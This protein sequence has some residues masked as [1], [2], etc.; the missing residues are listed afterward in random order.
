MKDAIAVAAREAG[1]DLPRAVLDDKARLEA[2]DPLGR[3]AGSGAAPRGRGWGG[4][5]EGLSHGKRVAQLF[6]DLAEGP[7]GTP[8]FVTDYP[9]EVSPLARPA[10][11]PVAHRALRAVRGGHGDRRTASRDRRPLE[12]RQ[13]F[14]DQSRERER[15][16][17]EATAWTTTTLRALG[18]GLPPTGGC[19]VGI[20][21]LSMI[22]TNSPSIRDVILFPHMRPA[23]EGMRPSSA[24]TPS[25][26]PFELL[27][28]LRYLT[29]KRKQAFIS[30]ISAI[31]V[32]GVVVGVMALMVALGLM[33][34]LQ[35]EIRSKILGTTAH[36]SLFRSRGEGFDDY[37]QVV[38]RAR[39]L[40]HVLG[41]APAVYGKGI[42]SSG[43]S[44]LAT[45]KGIVPSQER[46][47]T[48]IGS[49]V[50][51]GSLDALDKP[52]AEG[53]PPILLGRELASQIGVGA[54]DVVSVTSPNG[55][56]SPMGVL[57]RVTKFR[58]AGVVKSGLYEFDAGWP[59]CLWRPPS[60]CS[61]RAT[62]RR[63]WSFGSTT[64]TPCARS[65]VTWSRPS[66]TG[67]CPATGSTSTRAC[68]RPSG[69]RRWPSA[70]PSGSS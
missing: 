50:E 1:L 7:S 29:A 15:G 25:S 22:L 45:F 11:R 38:E 17:L 24:M 13:R 60:A 21:R 18:H 69:W 14:L 65:A 33:T 12:Q 16:D 9:V 55:R 43:G 57:P 27:I 2:V 53:P 46:T 36:V 39:Q 5:Y 70:S 26:M 63:W 41:A 49:Q 4:R 48:D 37:R 68:S 3:P 44:A 20:D 52:P 56:L 54:G 35:K 59:T 62:G 8:A 28:A 47:V 61:W 32:L 30:I 42:I 58:V 6:E 51:D 67:T 66:A 34:G 19:G 23:D 31:S 64:S 10:R 40:P